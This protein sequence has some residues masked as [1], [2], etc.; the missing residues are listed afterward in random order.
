MSDHVSGWRFVGVDDRLYAVVP[1]S[2]EREIRVFTR[3]W[4]GHRSAHVREFYDRDHDGSR[5]PG[6]G[7]TF[8]PELAASLAFGLL[9]VMDE[10]RDPAAVEAKAAAAALGAGIRQAWLDAGAPDADDIDA[11]NAIGDGIVAHVDH[12]IG[13]R[14]QRALQPPTP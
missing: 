6:R 12:T 10:T 14:E 8:A 13:I 7:V 11:W 5:H 3:E 9:L 1:L 2:P 4:G